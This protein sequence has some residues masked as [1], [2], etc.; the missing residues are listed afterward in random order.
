VINTS[1]S[2][3]LC[4]DLSRDSR[5]RIVSVALTNPRNQREILLPGSW[6]FDCDYKQ[7]KHLTLTF[8]A[9]ASQPITED[10]RQLKLFVEPPLPAAV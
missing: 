7:G 10:P 8:D 1:K 4:V 6:V 3:P 5:G 9:S 2:V